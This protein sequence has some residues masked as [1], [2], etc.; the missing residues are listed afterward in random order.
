MT[1]SS[2]DENIEILTY[3]EVVDVKGYV[4]NFDVRIRK[5]PRYVDMSKCT[6]CA[7]C[8]PGCPVSLPSEFNLGLGKR[9]AIYLPFPQAVPLK[10]T[11]DRR[12]TPP[13]E[14]SCPIHVN[15]QGYIALISAGKFEEAFS[16]VKEKNPF[17]GITGRICTRPCERACRR[18]DVDESIAIDALKRFL[19]DR[20]GNGEGDIVITEQNGKNVAIVGSGPAG[21]LA[22][23][24][25]RKMG[26]GVTIF[27]TLPVAGGMLAVGIPEYRLP[28]R[29]LN[30]EIEHLLRMG[31]ELRLNTPIGPCL[32]FEDL[33]TKGYRAIFVATGAHQSRKLGLEGES[34]RGVIHAVDFLRRV[35]LGESVKVGEKA[36]VIGGGNAAI[37]AAR[38]ALRLGSQEVTIAYRR[39]RNEMPAQIDEI[40]GAEE[41]GIKIEYL[42]A[43]LRVIAQDGEVRGLECCRMELKE[44]DES[45]RPRPVPISGSE[46][47]MD[48]DTILPAISQSPD[49][50]F[51]SE[52]DRFKISRWG[53]LEADPLTLETGV[54]GIFAGGDLVTGPQ[55][56]IDAMAAGRKAAVSIDR[57]LRGEDL[58]EGREKEGPQ[59]EFIQ[60]DVDGVEYREKASMVT[61]SSERRKRSFD[62]VN[63]GLR[64]EDVI[65][66]AERCLNCGGCSACGECSKICQ[67]KAIDYEMKEEWIERKVGAIIVATGFSQFDHKVYGEYGGGRF[68]DVITGLHL[69]RMLDTAGPTGGH[70][71]RPSNGKEAKNIVFLQ[72][73]GSRDES[74]GVPYCSKICCMYTAKQAILLKDHFPETQSYVFYIDIRASG[75]NYEEFVKRA[76]REYGVVYIRGRVSKIYEKGDKLIVRGVDTLIGKQVELEADLVVLATAVV[77]QPGAVELARLLNIPYDSYGFYTECHPKLQPVEV[78]TKGIFLTGACQF[79]RDIPDS[80]ATTGAASVR[81]CEILSKDELILDPRIA[82]V[83][84]E[85]CS[86]CLNCVGVCP[87]KAIERKEVDGKVV[88]QVLPTLCHGC[89]NCAATCRSGAAN[90]QGFTDDQIY[91]Q[92]ASVFEVLRKERILELSE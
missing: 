89:G 52:K 19:S 63:L 18:K 90:V 64:E 4:G 42:T 60:I 23:H 84:E 47:R 31:I 54:E 76:Q 45:G 50:S 14:A 22:A 80:I 37:D 7:D 32:S 83:D 26:Y 9:K 51:L 59:K 55:T 6:A 49:L 25:L 86:G 13:C 57:Y 17:P 75:K 38:T 11:I 72:C 48:A 81:A 71:L 29:I 78:V 3:S 79:P 91:A 30:K 2:N 39:T 10:Y 74:K 88:A 1:E 82:F 20:D 24:D 34:A 66:E 21:L 16:L 33:K 8:V 70:V 92:V 67:P 28:R 73:V 56:Y 58:R 12:G 68:K 41:E 61:L 15:A 44:F 36:V 5:K 65:H 85:V 40:E 62:E 53:G 43:P 87:F 77:P 46:F 35:A 69:E 27:E